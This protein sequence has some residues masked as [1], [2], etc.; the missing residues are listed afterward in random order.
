MGRDNEAENWKLST[1]KTDCIE[2]VIHLY[3]EI[4]IA[5][6]KKM[7]KKNCT[8]F[9]VFVIFSTNL[10]SQYYYIPDS[11]L[12][13]ELYGMEFTNN[14]S[15]LDANKINGRLQLELSGKGI[16]NLD[17]LQYFKQVWNLNISKNKIKELKNLPPNLTKLVCVENEITKLENLPSTLERL[18]CSNNKIEVINSLP[19]KLK[20]LWCSNN[21]IKEITNLPN[22]LKFLAFNNNLITNFPALPSNLESI[23]YYNNPLDI[24]VLPELYRNNIPCSH[25]R[26]N[27]LP[28]ELLNWKPLSHNIK[29]TVFEILGLKVTINTKFGW[30]NGYETRSINFITKNKKLICKNEKIYRTYGVLDKEATI[31]DKENKHSINI[32]ELEEFLKDL[33]NRKM[34]FEFQINDSIATVNLRT[35]RNGQFLC[36]SSCVDCSFLEYRYDIYTKKDTISLSYNS[37]V[38]ETCIAIVTDDFFA[39]GISPP[40][41]IRAI[42]NVLYV[43]KLEEMILKKEY[44]NYKLQ[45]ILEWDRNYK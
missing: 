6:I 35:K 45:N 34:S 40:E 23:N 38:Y 9:I 25:P 37:L 36:W 11:N 17:G 24:N 28:Y 12:R 1:I 8:C 10:M 27:C 44:E 32:E 21:L 3:F 39:L 7:K 22:N 4:A 19:Y 15:L 20:Y 43:Y 18:D 16:E 41:D 29:D 42:L 13:K 33:Y 31:E 5:K 26:Q 30:G 2:F 14:D